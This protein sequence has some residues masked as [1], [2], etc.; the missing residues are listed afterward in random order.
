VVRLNL[1]A[2]DEEKR[3][4][5]TQPAAAQTDQEA[6]SHIPPSDINDSRSGRNSNVV[7][8]VGTQFKTT[9]A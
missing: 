9:L 6:P 1:L 5:A 4:S 3:V 8:N 7:G 2:T